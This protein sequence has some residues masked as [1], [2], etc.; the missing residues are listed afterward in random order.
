MPHSHLCRAPI[1]APLSCHLFE[2]APIEGCR[3]RTSAVP[4]FSHQPCAIF[5][6]LHLWGDATLAP[7]LRTN[8]VPS[9]GV[10]TSW[11]LGLGFAPIFCHLS[12]FAPLG[13]SALAPLRCPHFRTSFVPSFRVCTCWGMPHSHL[14][15]APIFAPTLRHLFD[16][17]PLGGCYTR[18]SAA[19][20]YCP[21]FWSLHLLGV[22]VRVSGGCCISPM[23]PFSHQYFATFSSLHLL[24]DAEIA[25]L[26]CPHFRT[27]M[28]PPFSHLYG[29]IFSSLHLLGDAGTSVAPSF[30]TNIAPSFRVCNSWGMLHSHLGCAPS[31]HQYFAIFSSLHLLGVRAGVRVSGG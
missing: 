13:H 5:S 16:F 2:F 20:Q 24:G 31:S 17:A 11:G 12:E 8:I 23:P 25:P 6:T 29:A 7:L 19:H 10:C 30:G 27:S 21:I 1:F 15:G 14:C 18:T 9:F 26:R 22:R 28:V 3:T 4:P